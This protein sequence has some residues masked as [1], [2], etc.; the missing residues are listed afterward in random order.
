MGDDVER[1]YAKTLGEDEYQSAVA[2]VHAE[3]SDLGELP[4]PV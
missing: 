2:R 4:G 1:Y 3:L